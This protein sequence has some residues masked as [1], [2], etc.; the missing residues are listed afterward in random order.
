TTLAINALAAAGDLDSLPDRD[1]LL[2][3]ILEQQ[4]NE[5]HPYTGAEPGG[6]GWSHLSGS[7]PD[8]DDTPGTLLALKHLQS[9]DGPE[10]EFP[11]GKPENYQDEFR[12]R[13]AQL[14]ANP[15]LRSLVFAIAS[16]IDWL[17]KLQNNDG[18]VP[19]FCRG[20]GRLPF[21]RSGVDLTA[22]AL[23]S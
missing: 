22:H 13:D 20:W 16:G 6:W 17:H 19:T 8:A 11:V 18:G 7:V 3:W 15:G 9:I 2:A 12:I 5:R 14:D 10:F 1:K 23:R 21:D 4:E